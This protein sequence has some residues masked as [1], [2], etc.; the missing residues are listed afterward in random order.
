MDE[1]KGPVD[2][3][4]I[5]RSDQKCLTGQVVVV[6]IPQEHHFSKRLVF[7]L[8]KACPQILCIRVNIPLNV[9]FQT[10]SF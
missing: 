3:N 2:S 1:R 8:S 7:A 5:E 4:L 9:S 10:P 6:A